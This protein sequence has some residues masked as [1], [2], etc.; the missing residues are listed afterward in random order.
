MI[1]LSPKQQVLFV[2]IAE[3]RISDDPSHILSAPNLGSC[4]GVAVYDPIFK[5]GGLVHCLV[6]LSK[7]DPQKAIERPFMYVDTGVSELLNAMLR[8]G[9]RKQDILIRVAG[10]ASINDTNGYFEIGKKNYTVLRKV[11]WKNN[12]LI[13]SEHIGGEHSR[14]V[15]LDIASGQVTV[16]TAGKV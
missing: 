9:S 16:R 3:M 10:G 15:S 7:N 1:S 12:L 2:G 6:P 13:T 4:L 8:A 14:T 5:R 11:L